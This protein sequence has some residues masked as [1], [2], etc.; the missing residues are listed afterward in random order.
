MAAQWPEALFPLHSK[1]FLCV[2]WW[3]LHSLHCNV[4]WAIIATDMLEIL[5]KTSCYTCPAPNPATRHTWSRTPFFLKEVSSLPRTLRQWASVGLIWRRWGPSP[6]VGLLQAAFPPLQLDGW[7]L[8][9]SLGPSLWL[10]LP[11]IPYLGPWKHVPKCTWTH[12]RVHNTHGHSTAKA[13]QPSHAWRNWE[14]KN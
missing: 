6:L 14:T 12:T 13:E 5:L 7:H 2:F 1:A 11:H 9:L 10:F 8:H 3:I 4:S